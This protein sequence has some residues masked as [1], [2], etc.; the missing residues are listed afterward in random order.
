MYTKIT[1]HQFACKLALIILISIHFTVEDAGLHASNNYVLNSGYGVLFDQTA[2]I[3][4]MSNTLFYRHTF[5]YRWPKIEGMTPLSR[6][7]CSVYP[8]YVL[9][10]CQIINNII[11]DVNV[12][13]QT[14]L[15]KYK[16]EFEILQNLIPLLNDTMHASTKRKKRNSEDPLYARH[17]V[18]DSWSSLTDLPGWKSI[19]KTVLYF[20]TLCELVQLNVNAIS[21]FESDTITLSVNLHNQIRNLL[22]RGSQTNVN[23]Q[24]LFVN[25]QNLKI[26]IDKFQQN[27]TKVYNMT[28]HIDA[29]FASTIMPMLSDV[30]R[31]QKDLAMSY[32]SWSVGLLSLTRGYLS[33]QIVSVDQ[34]DKVI[35]KIK[36]VIFLQNHMM[37]YTLASYDPLYFY[38]LKR[39]TYGREVD[40]V[41]NSVL[42]VYVEVPLYESGNMLKVYEIKVFPVPIQNDPESLAMHTDYTQIINTPRFIAFDPTFETYIEMS[43]EMYLSCEGIGDVK[44]CDRG[45]P[46]IKKSTPLQTCAYALYTNHHNNVKKYCEFKLLNTRSWLAPSLAVQLNEDGKYLIFST[47]L[48]DRNWRLACH[49]R[50]PS[51][52]LA[53]TMCI[54]KIKCGCTLANAHYLLPVKYHSQC[55]DNQLPIEFK[56]VKNTFV[57]INL[58]NDSMK[59]NLMKYKNELDNE[60]PY[61]KIAPITFKSSDKFSQFVAMS[62]QKNTDYKKIERAMQHN[63]TVY[64]TTYHKLDKIARNFSDVVTKRKTDVVKALGVLT[65]GIFGSTVAKIL[66]LL[67]VPAF[68]NL[69]VLTYLLIK[70]I[71]LTMRRTMVRVRKKKADQMYS[72]L[73]NERVHY[74]KR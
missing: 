60:L 16:K 66:S 69:I 68:F 11:S 52:S 64:E 40:R 63:I 46:V 3:L 37:R 36:N 28:M 2:S 74:V 73:M 23:L 15:I 43:V 29:Y 19:Q 42:Y 55:D 39:I 35:T 21:N 1:M 18:A 31:F 13:T 54:V 22:H 57:M 41:G 59:Q 33:P 4:S 50:A 62:N 38:T 5:K 7:N 24:K 70:C 53:C 67:F 25:L 44:I 72:M 48:A 61:V 32:N 49:G 26:E 51:Y 47:P 58:L 27:M 34:I 20:K 12:H 17:Y 56:Y 30:W 10:I 71:P 14:T 65:E 8:L 45:V 6:A 9:E